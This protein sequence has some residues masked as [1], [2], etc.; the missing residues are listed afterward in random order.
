EKKTIITLTLMKLT[1][2]LID[3]D[4]YVHSDVRRRL[5][6]IPNL[7]MVAAFTG[8]QDALDY[9]FIHEEGVD[10]VLCDILMPDIDGY[11]AAELL[12]GYYDMLLFLTGKTEH[13]EE[14][15]GSPALGYLKKPVNASQVME[16]L[17]QLA[18][19]P[20]TGV[21]PKENPGIVIL[22]DRKSG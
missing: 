10:I 22:N 17:N 13:G 20:R 12:Y 16:K 3:D 19:L 2:V 21:V 5:S 9:F 1:F 15:F 18:G 8:V 6:K 4:V 11:E 14:V 7:N